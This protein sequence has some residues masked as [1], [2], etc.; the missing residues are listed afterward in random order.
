MTQTATV[1]KILPDGKAEVAVERAECSACPSAAICG[2][3]K[4][5][6]VKANNGLNANIGDIVFVKPKGLFNVEIVGLQTLNGR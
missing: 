3:V 2:T 5:L 6:M 1:I 4:P